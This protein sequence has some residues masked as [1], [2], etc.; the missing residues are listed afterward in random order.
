MTATNHAGFTEQQIAS[1]SA[2]L[3]RKNVS[4][5]AGGGNRQLSYIEGWHAINE[6][7]RI[8]GFDGWSARTV[9]MNCTHSAAV[10]GFTVCGYMAKVEVTVEA[11][12]RRIV[13]EGFGFG[14][15]KDR[16]PGQSH[17]KAIKE[18][19]TDARKRALVTFGNPF[20]LALYDK[21]QS[22]VSDN[23][24]DT[25]PA[26]L[27]P[28]SQ[29]EHIDPET[30]EILPPP[31][32][33]PPS[34][35]EAE[36]D[37]FP[38]DRKSAKPSH[39]PEERRGKAPAK[40]RDYSRGPRQHITPDKKA[41]AERATET[42]SR[43]VSKKMLDGDQ[44]CRGLRQMYADLKADPGKVADVAAEFDHWCEIARV[45]RQFLV[46]DDKAAVDK[47]YKMLK[48][49]IEQSSDS[50]EPGSTEYDAAQEAA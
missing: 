16:D 47:G 23:V 28:P 45:R 21:E 15:G 7:N 14:N 42:K 30:G 26:P 49:A 12:G 24:D 34:Q 36:A 13:R 19:E 41:A 25:L 20:G 6:A 5:R 39:V 22:S 35:E 27:Q 17:E 1:L 33:S 2:D 4:Q 37:V 43:D 8:F 3:D 10:N 11:G 31:A 40:P 18:A 46:S 32:R 9:V 44:I 29:P 50:A 48:T 38:A